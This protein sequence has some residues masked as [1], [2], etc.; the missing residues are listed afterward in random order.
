MPKTE[1]SPF[2]INVGLSVEGDTSERPLEFLTKL[3]ECVSTLIE[4]LTRDAVERAREQGHTWAEI[5]G[6]LGISRQ[7][8]WER[9]APGD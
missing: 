9:F 2:S 8:A 1:S 6:A 4:D 3:T 7:A 5:G